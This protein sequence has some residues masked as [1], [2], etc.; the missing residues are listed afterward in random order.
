MKL[1]LCGSLVFW[2]ATAAGQTLPDGPGKA[3]VQRM[4]TP[5]HG[6]G[7]VVRA[8]MTKERWGSVVDDMVSRGAKGTDDEID[9]V[10]DYLAANFSKGAAKTVNINKAGAVDLADALEISAAD[11]A[12]IVSYRR[13]K[14][15]FKSLQDV[16]RVPGIDIKKIEAAKDRLEF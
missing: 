12:A 6:L 9:Q 7:S 15:D 11:A 3:I 1:L 13:D 16:T 2:L 5:C 14:G 4:C 10:I 8:R